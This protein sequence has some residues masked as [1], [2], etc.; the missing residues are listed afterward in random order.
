MKKDD[1]S[2]R[3]APELLDDG[4]VVKLNKP[5]SRRRSGRFTAMARLLQDRTAIA[6]MH[7]GRQI[8]G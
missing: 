3:A 2:R 5:A 4:G 1:F 7:V 8:G 6:K